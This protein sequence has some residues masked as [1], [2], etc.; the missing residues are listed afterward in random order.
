MLLVLAVKMSARPALK[1]TS[2]ISLRIN[3]E[4]SDSSASNLRNSDSLVHHAAR[5][6]DAVLSGST[7]FEKKTSLTRPTDGASISGLIDDGKQPERDDDQDFD[8]DVDV[9]SSSDNENMEVSLICKI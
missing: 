2:S 3:A 8:T 6:E 1:R 9:G 4:H 5:N 7:S